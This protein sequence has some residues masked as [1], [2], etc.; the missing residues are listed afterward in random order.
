[1]PG[2]RRGR[3]RFRYRPYSRRWTEID[4]LEL[5]LLGTGRSLVPA[6]RDLRAG[7]AERGLALEVMDTCAACRTYNVLLAEARSVAAALIAVD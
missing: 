2:R 6:A 3:R 4:E 5:L 1:M 7:F